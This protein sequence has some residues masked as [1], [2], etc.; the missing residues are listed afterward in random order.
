MALDQLDSERWVRDFEQLGL[1]GMVGNIASHCTLQKRQ[2]NRLEL[3]LDQHNASLFN[4]AQLHKL[5][6]QLSKALGEALEV[7]VELGE[8]SGETPAAY[9]ARQLAER[10]A[11]ARASIENDPNVQLLIERFGATL[12][13]ESIE[14]LDQ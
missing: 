4:D 5:E 6:Q 13:P 11:A 12:D 8:V 7:A 2:G 10:R 14:P 9:R 1:V 3:L